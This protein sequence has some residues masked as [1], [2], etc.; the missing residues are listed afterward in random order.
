MPE[1]W[2]GAKADYGLEGG[3]PRQGGSV[4]ATPYKEGKELKELKRAND[5]LLKKVGQLTVEVDF[6]AE[7]YETLCQKKQ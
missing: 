1:V 3:V 2:S 4:F 7:A 5:K 6:F